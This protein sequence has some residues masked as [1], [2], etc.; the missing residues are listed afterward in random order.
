MPTKMQ[1]QKDGD[2]SANALVGRPRCQVQVCMIRQTASHPPAGRVRCGLHVILSQS[3]LC[4]GR[5][6]ILTTHLLDGVAMRSASPAAT[7][8]AT[9]TDG[10]MASWA[11]PS[12]IMFAARANCESKEI[13]KGPAEIKKSTSVCRTNMTRRSTRAALTERPWR[14]LILWFNFSTLPTS[15]NRKA[16]TT[17]QTACKSVDNRQGSTVVERTFRFSR[18]RS[19]DGA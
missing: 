1:T 13:N 2:L 12:D 6:A 10:T 19:R 18:R 15:P 14:E 7:G 4:A 5:P 8:L 17:S 3:H 9:T 16:T 11:G